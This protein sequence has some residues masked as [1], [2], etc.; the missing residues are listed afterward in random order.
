VHHFLRAFDKINVHLYYSHDDI[1]MLAR[2]IVSVRRLF[3]GPVVGFARMMVGMSL[4]EV[5]I[6]LTSSIKLRVS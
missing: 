3:V 6:E 5:R 2:S 1:L 4:D